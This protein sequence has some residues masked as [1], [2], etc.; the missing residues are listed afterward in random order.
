[1]LRSL[2]AALIRFASLGDRMKNLFGVDHLDILAISKDRKRLLVVKL[3]KRRASDAFV[4]Q[5]LR[6][7]SFVQG[8]VG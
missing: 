1:M 6:H 7:M 5:T 8:V 4:G 3:K 2:A